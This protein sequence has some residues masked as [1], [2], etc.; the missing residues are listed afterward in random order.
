MSNGEAGPNYVELIN[1]QP[2]GWKRANGLRFLTASPDVLTAE[3]PIG[4]QHLQPY[5][6]VHGGVYAGVVESLASIGAAIDVMPLGKSAVGLENHT[7]FIRACRGGTLHA[8]ATPIVK[9]AR[10]QAWEVTI[11]DDEERVLAVGRVRLLVLDA[12]STVAGGTLE[13]RKE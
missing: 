11:R 4:P 8:R 6:I 3:M 10:S 1:A 7:S 5:G 9:G 12:T 2:D 13:V